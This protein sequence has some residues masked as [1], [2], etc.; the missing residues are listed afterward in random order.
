MADGKH[1][2]RSEAPTPG[3]SPES[4]PEPSTCPKGI[5]QKLPEALSSFLE[6]NRPDPIG[7]ELQKKNK[8]NVDFLCV[9]IV[10]I[11][12]AIKTIEK[13]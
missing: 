5:F 3:R 6:A 8:E 4:I 9:F 1:V 7:K 2:I 10:F 13:H 11:D 12:F